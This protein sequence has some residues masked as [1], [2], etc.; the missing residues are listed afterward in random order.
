MRLSFERTVEAPREAVFA[1]FRDAARWP[2]FVSGIES[3]AGA[4]G[5]LN[6]GDTFR[7][8]RTMF[9]REA[10]ETFAVTGLRP[11]EE[12]TLESDSCGARF[13][14]RHTFEDAGGGR[15]R[16]RLEMTS[17]PLTLFAKLMSPLGALMAGSMRKAIEK[18]LDEFAAECERAGGLAS[19]PPA[20]G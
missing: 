2:E 18:D 10:T 6:V 19:A 11:G 14:S 3:V 15:T 1:A 5:P 20:G 17:R 12:L 9:G 16:V 4:E 8:T 13:V 7:E